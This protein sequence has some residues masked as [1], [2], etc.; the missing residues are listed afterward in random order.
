MKYLPNSLFLE[1]LEPRSRSAFWNGMQCTKA[2][3]ANYICWHIGYGRFF[4]F[5]NDGWLQK[6]L[7]R[8]HALIFSI[9]RDLSTLYGTK[10]QDFILAREHLVWK[11]LILINPLDIHWEAL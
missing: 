5:W 9:K 2:F 8:E 11:P 3:L 10:A 1:D 6:A 4:N 7:L